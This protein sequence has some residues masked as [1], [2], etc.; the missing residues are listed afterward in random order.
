SVR[1]E[2]SLGPIERT[3][4]ACPALPTCGQALTES[5]R[6]L[7]ELVEALEGELAASAAKRRPLQLRMTGCPN[8]CA[9]P[10]V[11]EI[12]VVGRTKSTYD[13]VL[14]GSG[15]GDRLA[16]TYREKVTVEEI[17]PIVGP[18]F[19][20]WGQEAFADESFGDFVTRVGIA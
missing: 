1:G 7:P 5:E 18:L 6:R 2:Q 16:R 14:G 3:A 4:L 12:G 17:A 13:L 20:R 8:G 9:R 19:E 10:A 11:A 15:R